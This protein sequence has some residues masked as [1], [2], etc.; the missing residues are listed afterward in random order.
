[1]R[2]TMQGS[3]MTPLRWLTA[4]VGIATACAVLAQSPA[5]APKEAQEAATQAQ[6]QR[7]QPGNNAPVWKEIRSGDPQI[8]SIPGRETNVLIQPWGQTWRAI[9]DGRIAVFGGWA[10]VVVF[11]TVALFYG[12]KGTMPLHAPLTGRKMPRFNAWER[13]VHWAT[14]I[15]F[16]I[17]AIS[18]LIIFFGKNI[19]LPLIGYTL[20]SWLAII[21]KNLH[22]FVG[23]LFS[24]CILLLFLTFVRDNFLRG[25]DFAWFRKFGGLFS[26]EHVPS[27]R[28][29]GGEKVWFWGGVLFLG[30]IV[31]G[32]GLVLDFPN[33]NQTRQTMQFANMIHGIASILLM[34]GAIGHIYMGTIGMVGAFDAM[35]TGYVD[36]AWAKEHHEYWYNDVK[37]GK[38][39]GE[40]AAPVMAH[41]AM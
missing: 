7:A 34:M 11:L 3:L 25:Y 41:R 12:V 30:S 16:S 26:G 19:L 17:L 33:F 37:A 8:T 18:G 36:E 29:N 4:V 23:P 13:S 28:F 22:N 9:R 32:S 15:S 31:A 39:E 2:L 38:V 6:Q 5:V 24:V 14:A 10:L 21:A 40:G 20:F 35:R 1:M 27:G